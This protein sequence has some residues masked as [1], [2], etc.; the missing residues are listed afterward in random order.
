MLFS[1]KYCVMKWIT[2]TLTFLS[3][4]LESL[5][6]IYTRNGHFQVHHKLN[7]SLQ[8]MSEKSLYHFILAYNSE[9]HACY[10]KVQTAIS[11]LF[12]M[13][14]CQRNCLEDGYMRLKRLHENNLFSQKG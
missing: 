3:S 6:I 14:N 11:D 5:V 1:L 2:V 9:Q 4:F 10:I 12:Y 13:L 7:K 8:L